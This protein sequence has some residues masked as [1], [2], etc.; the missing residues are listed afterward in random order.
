MSWTEKDI[1][2]LSGKIAIV[3]GANSGLGFQTTYYLAK[4]N[5][6][7]ILACRS[8]HKAEKSLNEIMQ[9][10]PNADLEFIQLDLSDFD[11]VKKFAATFKAKFNQLDILVN[12]AGIGGISFYKTIED[13]EMN[14][15]TNHIGHFLLVGQLL[16]QLKLTKNSRVVIVSSEFNRI[17]NHTFDDINY[18]HK[19]YH[20]WHAYGKSKLANALFSNEL[21]RRFEEN[22]YDAI[23]VTVHPGYS[24]TNL[25]QRGPELE[26]A[27]LEAKILWFTNKVIAQSEKMGSMPTLYAATAKDVYGGDYIGPKF[28]RWRGYPSKQ[29]A[30]KAAYDITLAKKLWDISEKMTN[31]KYSF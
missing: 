21:N 15:G 24:N 25:Q 30:R 9:L 22:G 17:G 10:L 31:F 2:N 28:M 13:I 29:K 19:K 23:S 16:P 18:E 12:N 11:S 14:F 3:T 20:K 4:N 26:N 27:K 5:A 8:K 1:P 6:K 7:V